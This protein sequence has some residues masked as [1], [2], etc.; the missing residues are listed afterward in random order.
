LFRQ[1]FSNERNKRKVFKKFFDNFSTLGA[2]EGFFVAYVTEPTLVDSPKAFLKAMEAGINSEPC[3][4]DTMPN[5]RFIL[6]QILDCP[7]KLLVPD[8]LRFKI[9]NMAVYILFHV[10]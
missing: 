5:L 3:A 10:F 9:K 7:C 4:I 2:G 1:K 6:Q 8:T